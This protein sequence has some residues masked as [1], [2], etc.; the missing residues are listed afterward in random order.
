MAERQWD[1]Q[2]PN[3]EKVFLDDDKLIVV[4][5][6]NG[7]KVRLGYWCEGSRPVKS[8]GGILA[9]MIQSE[10]NQE[11]PYLYLHV[12]IPESERKPGKGGKPK[13]WASSVKVPPPFCLWPEDLR[14]SVAQW[15]LSIA[16]PEEL[17]SQLSVKEVSLHHIFLSG[18]FI[19][20]NV[21]EGVEL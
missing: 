13:R 8:A 11:G 16:G 2:G 3:G 5:S 6:S 14:I 9:Q 4:E 19:L 10:T 1:Q 21:P 7:K 20:L 17:V 12:E 15:V 18:F